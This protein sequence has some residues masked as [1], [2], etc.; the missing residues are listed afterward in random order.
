MELLLKPAAQVGKIIIGL[1]VLLGS[2]GGRLLPQLLQVVGPQI[3]QTLL[4]GDDIHGEFF[5]VLGIQF[6]HLVQHGD[7]LHQYHLVVLQNPDDLIYIDLGLGIAGLHRLQFVSLLLE[8]AEQAALFL[9]ILT[10]IFQF[11]HQVGQGLA[12]LAQILGPD[13]VQGVL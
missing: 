9:L 10:K 6:I 4:A 2:A 12:H 5:V 7:V 13:A 3:L 1:G 8:K 11:H